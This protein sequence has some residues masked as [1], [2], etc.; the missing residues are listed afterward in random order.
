MATLLNKT[1]GQTIGSISDAQ[2]KFLIDQ[3]EE[4]HDEDQE[5]WLS[6]DVLAVLEDAG[7]D[8]SLVAMLNQALG[9]L[10]E[11]DIAWTQP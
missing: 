2:L 6:R 3:L 4:E 8:G 7:A 11:I 9:E 1:T 10:E 5:Y